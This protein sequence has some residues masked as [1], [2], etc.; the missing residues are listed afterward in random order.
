MLDMHPLVIAELVGSALSIFSMLI[1]IRRRDDGI[2]TGFLS[3]VGWISM[4][5]SRVIVFALVALIISHWIFLLC[6]IHVLV[7]TVW[8]YMIAMKALEDDVSPNRSKKRGIHTLILIFFFFGLPS[9]VLWPYMFHLKEKQRP[10]KFLIVMFVE[11]TLMILFWY[12]MRTT[13]SRKDFFLLI[14]VIVTTVVATLFLSLYFCCKPSKVDQVVLHDMR[15]TDKESYGIYFEF[16]DIVFNL[17]VQKEVKELLDVIRE[18]PE[19]T[20]PKI[21]TQAS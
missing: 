12:F 21:S 11:N 9:L 14:L 2:L 1:A 3:F 4:F 16:C 6:S 5:T 7:F 20:T 8:V 15:Y 13:D 17:N 10:L 19:L 18:N